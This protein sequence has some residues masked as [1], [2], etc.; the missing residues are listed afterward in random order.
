MAVYRYGVLVYH[1]GLSA[2]PHTS[3]VVVLPSGPSK[4][5]CDGQRIGPSY[6]WNTAT[7]HDYC[8]EE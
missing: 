4:L 1:Y 7:L 5:S 8:S 6:G 2:L 3:G